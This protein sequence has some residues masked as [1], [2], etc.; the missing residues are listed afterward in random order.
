MSH[1]QFEARVVEH[2]LEAVV[3][4][5]FPLLSR[6]GSEARVLAEVC[7]PAVFHRFL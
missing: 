7:E 2:G 4:T 3:D 6:D 1:F 5:D